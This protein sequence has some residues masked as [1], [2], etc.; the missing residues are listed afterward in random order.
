[1]IS[2]N[3]LSFQIKSSHKL[4]AKPTQFGRFGEFY[5]DEEN[6]VTDGAFH[7]ICEEDDLIEEF[8]LEGILKP[9]V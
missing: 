7:D 3:V 2:C 9:S 8:R 1:M 6:E 4:L 5:S